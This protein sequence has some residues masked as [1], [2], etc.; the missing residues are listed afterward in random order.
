MT[1]KDVFPMI[2]HDVKVF[3]GS[4]GCLTP[5]NHTDPVIIDAF[6]DYELD[7]I[8]PIDETKIEIQL[9]MRPVKRSN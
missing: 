5:V 2:A 9:K 1:V 3:I 4:D 8:H 6:G 7:G